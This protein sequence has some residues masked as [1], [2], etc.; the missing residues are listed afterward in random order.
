MRGGGVE[1]AISVKVKG[2]QQAP[3][4]VT[5]HLCPGSVQGH[6]LVFTSGSSRLERPCVFKIYIHRIH[7]KF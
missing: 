3:F 7:T 1:G 2:Q 4:Q 6:M 5:Y